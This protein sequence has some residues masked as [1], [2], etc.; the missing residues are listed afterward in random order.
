[1]SCP[2]ST[3]HTNQ[4]YIYIYDNVIHVISTFG[5]D[6]LLVKTFKSV[7]RLTPFKFQFVKKTAPTLNQKLCHL[8]TLSWDH[9]Y[10]KPKPCARSRCKCCKTMSNN[11]TVIGGDGKKHKVL[12][13]GCT[14]D[15]VIYCATCKHCEHKLYVGKTTN[16]LAERKSQHKSDFGKVIGKG[17]SNVTLNDS[18]DSCLR[19]TFVHRT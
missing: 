9:H 10:G 7:E 19:V 5:C 11:G 4:I 14:A 17:M 1:M 8:K 2:T 18:H 3:N 15:L 16:T 6:N 13:S 12:D